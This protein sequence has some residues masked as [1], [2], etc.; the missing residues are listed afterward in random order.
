MRGFPCQHGGEPIDLFGMGGGTR[1]A[2]E[3]SAG[4]STDVPVL[5]RI[6]FDV[7]LR[8]GGDSGQPL[9]L[10]DPASPAAAALIEMATTLARKPRGL[11]GVPLNITPAGR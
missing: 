9:V 6:P 5:G 7:R 11:S 1:V 8:E 4:L 3:L 2:E 10:S